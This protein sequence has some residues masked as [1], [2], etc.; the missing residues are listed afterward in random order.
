MGYLLL[1][2]ITRIIYC[3]ITGG[4][5]EDLTKVSQCK[6]LKLTSQ[7]NYVASLVSIHRSQVIGGS[8][9]N[10]GV[11]TPEFL[12]TPVLINIQNKPNTI[13]NIGR[14]TV[15]DQTGSKNINNFAF[16]FTEVLVS[17][18]IGTTGKYQDP[19][20]VQD[21]WN[22]ISD[23]TFIQLIQ[24][25]HL[26]RARAFSHTNGVESRIYVFNLFFLCIYDCFSIQYVSAQFMQE[27][28]QLYMYLSN[29][30]RWVW[31]ISH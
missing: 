23:L 31:G 21:I 12:W 30:V 22:L 24:K 2:S 13:L 18:S 19:T 14:T 20:G 15:L 10:L 26:S 25:S 7:F 8:Q 28:M 27:Y 5:V 29:N 16:T 1:Y 9:F 11:C 17:G 6:F 4:T 3:H